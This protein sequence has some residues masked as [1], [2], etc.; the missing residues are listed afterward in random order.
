MDTLPKEILIELL[1]YLEPSDPAWA[2]MARVNRHYSGIVTAA[3]RKYAPPP[4]RILMY[5]DG[6]VD[7]F[8]ALLGIEWFRGCEFELPLHHFRAAMPEIDVRTFARIIEFHPH[9]IPAAWTHENLARWSDDGHIDLCDSRIAPTMRNYL[10]ATNKYDFIKSKPA[11][12]MRL[13]LFMTV[14]MFDERVFAKLIYDCIVI[15]RLKYRCP[16]IITS[17]LVSILFNNCCSIGDIHSASII[18]GFRRL[19]NAGKLAR[20]VADMCVALDRHDQTI[21]VITS[22]LMRLG[23][24]MIGLDKR[25]QEEFARKHLSDDNKLGD[26]STTASVFPDFNDD[27][28][29]IIRDDRYRHRFI[30]AMQLADVNDLI[31]I[32]TS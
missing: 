14:N 32:I 26:Y 20:I 13:V 15:D 22:S 30:D 8:V 17:E 25:C 21:R 11:G 29:Y 18:I 16:T 28:I 27:V 19:D 3:R 23:M 9:L 10:M 2:A 1:G 6:A 12:L 7:Y 4:E 31:E 5:F 24:A